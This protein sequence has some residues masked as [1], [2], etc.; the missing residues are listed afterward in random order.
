ML[1]IFNHYQTVEV[2]NNPVKNIVRKLQGTSI[3]L[4]YIKKKLNYSY[5]YVLNN[6]LKHITTT[7]GKQ[8]FYS[9]KVFVKWTDLN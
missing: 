1:S 3:A 8:V 6:V 5:I 4:L 9:H 2:L 7:K